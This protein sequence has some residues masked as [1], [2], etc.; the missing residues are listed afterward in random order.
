MDVMIPIIPN[1]S[2]N[3]EDVVYYYDMGVL[4][5]HPGT[6]GKETQWENET[7]PNYRLVFYFWLFSD[8]LEINVGLV[9]SP[10]HFSDS[11]ISDHLFLSPG[12]S[13]ASDSAGNRLFECV[14]RC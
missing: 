13:V 4:K 1:Y 8:L 2:F 10:D 5:V 7:L 11:Q 6:D 9:H 3:G 14:W 12:L